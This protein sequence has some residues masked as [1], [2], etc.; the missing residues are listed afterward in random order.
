MY[1]VIWRGPLLLIVAVGIS[2]LIVN[3]IR[4]CDLTLRLLASFCIARDLGTV[5]PIGS[6]LDH[7]AFTGLQQR[8]RMTNQMN[9]AF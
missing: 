6:P 4:V 5:F 9:E 2:A 1:R 3:G 7:V 8:G